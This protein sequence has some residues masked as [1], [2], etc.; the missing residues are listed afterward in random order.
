MPTHKPD[1]S[2]LPNAFKLPPEKAIEYFKSKGYTFSWDW[3]DT[4][5]EAHARAFTVAKA[6]R[7]DVLQDI[8]GMLQ[9]SLDEG[10]PFQQFKKELEPQLKAKGWWGKK[11]VGDDQGGTQIQLGSVRRLKTIYRTNMQ[12]AYMAGRYKGM[13]DVAMRR[14]YWMYIAVMDSKTRPGHKILHG[15]VFHH[16][17]PF[18]NTHYPPNGW[19]CRCRV[20][21]VS[22]REVDRDDHI[23]EAS[24]GRLTDNEVLLN[25][26]TGEMTTVTAYKDPLT[27]ATMAPDAG[28]N[29]NPG[30]AGWQPFTATP[31][32]PS[33]P[34]V[35]YKTLGAVVHKKT[36]IRSL[37][38]KL[39]NEDMLLPAHQ[40][41]KWSEDQYVNIFL[42][43]F[44]TEIGKTTIFKDVINNP[45]VIS[46][47]LFMDAKTGKLKIFKADREVYLKLL[48]ETIKEPV[49]IWLTWVKIGKE[50][51][52]SQRYIGVYKDKGEKIGGFVV[53][54]L[55]NDTW[56]GVTT[57][58]PGNL[59]YL[60]RQ[61]TGTLLYTKK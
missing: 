51:K 2:I 39:I 61:R 56:S 58:K 33:S 32:D 47:D 23:V 11:M 21:S 31:F 49:E 55:F 40:K 52:L 24:T 42:K 7:I 18:W 26:K 48:A 35:D 19:G 37:P 8:R 43:E 25:K 28:F 9:K 10:L 22:Q 50:V 13:K 41:S 38:A 45:I 34:P 57:F 46:K 44:S 60:D 20:K 15:K 16:T 30:K 36:P 27:G 14:P 5:Q 54:D 53:F 3:T 1:P 59:D 17:D 4:L 12:T 6:M 29:Y